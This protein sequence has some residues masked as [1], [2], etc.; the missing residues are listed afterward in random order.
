MS[1]YGSPVMALVNL[2]RRSAFVVCSGT[3]FGECGDDLGACTMRTHLVSTLVLL[4][5]LAACGQGSKGDQ[6]P[7]GDPGPAGPAGPAGPQG[8]QGIRGLP[9]PKGDQGPA[10]QGV[11]VVQSSCLRG[12]CIVECGS[13]EVLVTAYCGPNRRPATF[14]TERSASCGV[15]VNAVN[16]PIVAV[17][18]AGASQ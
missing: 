1:R 12:D 4:T 9:G 5:V 10:G 18:V 14:P 16:G 13:K 15:A 8:P 17:C 7:K 6:G 2:E 11:H 3:T